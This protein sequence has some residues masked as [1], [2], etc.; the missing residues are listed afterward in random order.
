MCGPFVPHHPAPSTDTR[1]STERNAT[2]VA[3]AATPEKLV[4]V[5]ASHAGAALRHVLTRVAGKGAG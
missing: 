5:A 1:A 4:R 2:P 3:L